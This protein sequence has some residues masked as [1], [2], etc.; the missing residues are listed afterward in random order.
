MTLEFV[1]FPDGPRKD[2]SWVVSL[3][4]IVVLPFSLMVSCS[5]Q[6]RGLIEKFCRFSI[7]VIGKI[8]EKPRLMSS[9]SRSLVNFLLCSST[10]GDLV[11][12]VVLF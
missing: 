9:D 10:K 7:I 6:P 1:D 5:W 11:V 4:F 3:C 2:W 8:R 12:L